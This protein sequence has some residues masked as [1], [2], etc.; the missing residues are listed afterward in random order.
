MIVGVN[1]RFL[2]A[3]PTGV[4]R[5]AR[6]VLEQLTRRADVALFLPRNA[7]VPE[8]LRPHLLRVHRGALRGTAWEQIELPRMIAGRCDVLLNP[9][10][11]APIRVRRQLVMVH[12][13]LPLTH[14]QWFAPAFSTW[15]GYMTPRLLARSAIILTS[16]QHCADQIR[17]VPSGRTA[18]VIV[19]PQGIAPFD[20]PADAKTVA[21]VRAE[22]GLGAP[23]VLA[24]GGGDRRKNVAFA[25]NVLRRYRDLHDGTLTLVVVGRAQ[26]HVHG[27]AM[28]A[29]AVDGAVHVGTVADEELRALYT[30]ASA[31]LFPSLGEGFGRPPLEAL[32]CGTP[33]LASDYPA[34]R[35]TLAD[36]PARRLPLDVGLWTRALRETLSSGARP[37]I[38]TREA[39]C[40]RWSW[41][42][43]AD[44]VLAAC[45]QAAKAP[46][47]AGVV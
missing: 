3:T 18:S 20:T 6:A 4:Q 13:V 27:R 9:A 47:A 44:A 36:T 2:A 35:E 38:E 32:C 17:A 34:G 1:G 8:V 24:L 11:T 46:V 16:S 42:A 15:Y 12:D 14:P 7:S 23:Y 37:S 45:A 25:M 29:E 39:L 22:R 26:K 31:F 43:A 5:F 10:H 19:V 33:V 41:D 40:A 21:G 28:R 30:G